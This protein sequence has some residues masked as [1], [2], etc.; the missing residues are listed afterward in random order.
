MTHVAILNSRQSKTPV[1]NDPWVKAT[2]SAV[3][4]A[5]ANNWSI[6]SSIGLNTWELVTWAAGRSRIPL[7]LLCP[8]DLSQPDRDTLVRRFD[9][10]PELVEWAFVPR[11]ERRSTIKNWWEHRDVAILALADRLLPVG[12]RKGGRIDGILA[13]PGKPIDERFRIP[14]SAVSHHVRDAVIAER[15]NPEVTNWSDGWLIHWTRASHGPWPGE[16]ESRYYAD[17]INSETQYCRSATETLRRI[18]AEARLRGSAWKI[19]ASVPVVA[20]TELSPV[21]SLALMRW[22]PRWSRWSFEPYGI[23]IHKRVAESLGVRP[24]RYVDSR[25]WRRV[26]DNEKPFTHSKGKNADVWPAEQEWRLVGDLSLERIS[27][28]DLRVITRSREELAVLEPGC[29][30]PVLSIEA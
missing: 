4:Y 21:E 6:I 16:T 30:Y 29:S 18:L 5:A 14:Y 23:A 27:A 2:L 10:S 3:E 12:V 25:E 13:T 15:L 7:T 9:L 19:G 1:G 28:E 8:D 22:R 26:P 20:F 24:V 17:V 11:G